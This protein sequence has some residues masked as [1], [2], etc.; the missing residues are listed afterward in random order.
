MDP[1]IISWLV[2]VSSSA[3]VS[4]I[5]ELANTSN[6][7]KIEILKELNDVEFK[8]N[9]ISYFSEIFKDYNINE[10]SKESY[11]LFFSNDLVIESVKKTLLEGGTADEIKDVFLRKLEL[12]KWE[13][14][15]NDEFKKFLKKYID[16]LLLLIFVDTRLE[17]FLQHKKLDR[18]INKTLNISISIDELHELVS[19]Q[20]ININEIKKHLKPSLKCFLTYKDYITGL[21]AGFSYK[22]VG[23]KTAFQVAQDFM[24]NDKDVLILYGN[25]GMGKTRFLMEL[26]K[27]F[28]KIFNTY[29]F[30]FIN[31]L[32]TDTNIAIGELKSI[33]DTNDEIESIVLVLDD[34]QDA[35]QTINYLDLAHNRSKYEIKTK[36]KLV[37]AARSYFKKS[38]NEIYSYGFLRDRALDRFEEFNLQ[39]DKITANDIQY[40]IPKELVINLS[41]I[42]NIYDGYPDTV[43][44]ACEAIKAGDDIS[45][46]TTRKG[47]LKFRFGQ[48]WNKL[49]DENKKAL[50]I[51][52][53]IR[54]YN[55][56]KD[57]KVET[58]FEN[59]YKHCF[60]DCLNTLLCDK[61]GYL[62][63]NG[64]TFTICRDLF[65]EYII[66]NEYFLKVGKI[67]EV[68][69]IMKEFIQIKA[70]EMGINFIKMQD[71]YSETC[72][73]LFAT[74][75]NEAQKQNIDSNLFLNTLTIV[76]ESYRDWVNVLKTLDHD[77]L[78]D[79]IDKSD[80]IRL[81]SPDKSDAIRLFPPIKW[82][83]IHLLC[84]YLTIGHWHSR[85][86]ADIEKNDEYD[87]ALNNLEQGIYYQN[88]EKNI[89]KA[90]EKYNEC[91]NILNRI[92]TFISIKY[93]FNWDEIPGKDGDKFIEFL[94]Q[95]FGTNSLK[96]AKFEKTNDDK[97]IRITAEKKSFLF[98]FNDEKTMANLVIDGLWSYYLK[99]NN[100]NLIL[101]NIKKILLNAGWIKEKEELINFLVDKIK[102]LKEKHQSLN[103]AEIKKINSIIFWMRNGGVV[104]L[105]QETV[106]FNV[107]PEVTPEII[108]YELDVVNGF[109]SFME[110]DLSIFKIVRIFTY[111]E[112]LNEEFYEYNIDI[113][114]EFSYD[115][116]NQIKNIIGMRT[117]LVLYPKVFIKTL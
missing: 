77:L 9:L 40:M 37:L 100:D 5:V 41:S 79:K 98:L 117:F 38:I 82:I 30:Y 35:P 26:V 24:V 42:E 101:Y 80:V 17:P 69:E 45:K 96:T 36:I 13:D 49:E 97:I 51:L 23:R 70:L 58:Y 94:R 75:F 111:D 2:G 102:I 21:G 92:E 27:S 109:F 66:N 7:K 86:G 83:Q 47:V 116:L 20:Y 71:R 29:T 81:S 39:Q 87:L 63:Y 15:D 112:L 3:F 57:Q 22:F 4:A 91:L 76:L 34:A 104:D 99:M 107:Y 43:I 114:K 28:Q 53:L 62:C 55:Q 12:N 46:L 31:N 25:P 73:Q 14:L 113:N 72:N 108:N 8:N 50:R 67:P 59:K 93:S 90:I 16:A 6:G 52:S 19:K 84:K 88:I 64:E 95:N 85:I 18:L 103:E 33:I 1:L 110:E 54:N 78:R 105:G 60:L 48:M 32:V 115:Y 106:L 65:A 10:S 89:Y 68:N 74:L 56:K 11:E 44:E 61:E